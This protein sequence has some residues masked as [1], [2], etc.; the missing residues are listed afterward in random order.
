MQNT[1]LAGVDLNLLPALDALLRRRNVSHAAADVGLSQPAMS[2]ALSRLR[3][4]LG[5]PLLVRGAGG[6]VLTPRAMRLAPIVASALVEIA[7]VYD[8]QAFDP[9]KAQT[10]I[11][12]AASDYQ[13]IMLA[14]AIMARLSAQAPGIDI[15][16]QPYSA[17][18]AQRIE[19]GALDLAFATRTTPLP[20]GAQ[21]EVVGQYDLALVMRRSHPRARRVWR[22]EDYAAYD[23]VAIALTGDGQSDL[24][25]LLAA[26]GLRRRIAL[27]TPHFMAA[28][29]TVSQTDLVTTIARD[30]AE[31]FADQF[32]LVLKEPPFE[33][34]HFQ[35]TLVWSHVR[36]NDP[37]LEWVRGIIRDVAMNRP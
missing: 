6:F 31:M 27:V 29:A 17:D 30:F 37:V 1:N 34:T 22:I 4:V 24:D 23:H 5:D 19:S 2:R 32:D 36:R 7:G 8:E 21:S 9:A 11:R 10:I 12:I 33:A 26:S 28:V 16:M 18:M 20:P 25:A 14:P 15:R 13:T 35:M 3:D